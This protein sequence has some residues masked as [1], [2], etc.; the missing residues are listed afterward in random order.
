[1]RNDLITHLCRCNDCCFIIIYC[2]FLFVSAPVANTRSL[3]SDQSLTSPRSCMSSRRPSFNTSTFGS[4]NFI[5]RTLSTNRAM[6]SPFYSGRTM[7]GGSAA[8]IA[9]SRSRT[10][11]P[12]DDARKLLVRN[13]IQIKPVNETEKT[14]RN[15]L[16]K[17]AKRILDVLENFST[18]VMDARRIP[19]VAEAKREAEAKKARTKPPVRELMV[20]GVPD[21]LRMKLRERLQDSTVA[22]RKVANSSKSVLNT[23]YETLL[24]S[25][26]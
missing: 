17:T 7:Y 2:M 1:M 26:Y 20:P 25:K 16:S 18:P 6:N 11:F 4:P 10:I 12:V 5:D 22:V 3:F 9:A 15:H 23:R 19:S 21:L 14:D 24:H 8:A 13:S